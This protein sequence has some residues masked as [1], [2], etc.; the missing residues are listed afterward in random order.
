MHN[1][2]IHKEKQ[3]RQLLPHLV[4]G[5]IVAWLLKARRVVIHVPHDNPYLVENDRTNQ[6]VGALDLNHYGGDGVGRLNEKKESRVIQTELSELI[7]PRRE[8]RH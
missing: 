5:N 4:D 2:L 7:K 6:L 1:V 3:Q 8:P